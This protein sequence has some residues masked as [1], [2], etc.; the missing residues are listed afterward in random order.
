MTKLATFWRNHRLGMFCGAMWTCIPLSMFKASAPLN[1]LNSLVIG[2]I[3]L[4]GVTSGIVVT[5]SFRPLLLGNKLRRL[6]WIAPLALIL[7]TLVYGF[8]YAQLAWGLLPSWKDWWFRDGTWAELTLASTFL[9]PLV[10]FTTDFVFL[11]LPL[12]VLNT[13]HLWWRANRL[14]AH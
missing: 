13:W 6:L 9:H 1:P 11:L 4:A 7:G 14:P 12:A 10:S 5:A 3:L 8:L 2:V